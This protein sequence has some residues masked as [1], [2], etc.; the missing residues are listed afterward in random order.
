MPPSHQGDATACSDCSAEHGPEIYESHILKSN[1]FGSSKQRKL[2]DLAPH[3]ASNRSPILPYLLTY[4]NGHFFYKSGAVQDGCYSLWG[5][6]VG[7][8]VSGYGLRRL[9]VS[10]HREYRWQPDSA[11]LLPVS[12]RWRTGT[13]LPPSALRDNN[14]FPKTPCNFGPPDSKFQPR[15]W[16]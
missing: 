12:P 8:P 4:L 13:H 9:D 7:I 1:F 5:N 16:R 14:S 11:V 2:N 6:C 3:Y 10:R 15:P